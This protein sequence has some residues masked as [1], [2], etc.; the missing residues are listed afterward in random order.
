M[1]WSDLVD[2]R[3]NSNNEINE[4]SQCTAFTALPD[5]YGAISPIYNENLE[6]APN[7]NENLE[8]QRYE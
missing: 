3:A 7:S 5:L 4:P 6:P 8:P 1:K 2:L